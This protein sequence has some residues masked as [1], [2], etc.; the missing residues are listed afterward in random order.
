MP[1]VTISVPSFVSGPHEIPASSVNT[2]GFVQKEIVIEVKT[3]KDSSE[4]SGAQRN[5]D[6]NVSTLVSQVLATETHTSDYEE[7]THDTSP[8]SEVVST[9]NLEITT[10]PGE[11]TPSQ[12]VATP[13]NNNSNANIVND[14]SSAAETVNYAN[15]HDE[16]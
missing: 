9:L 8:S 11:V 4:T 1:D 3:S 12:T 16:L 15:L 6:E 2:S 13:L 5:I 14:D 10:L 7:V